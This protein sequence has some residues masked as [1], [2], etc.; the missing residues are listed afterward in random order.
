M[1]PAEQLAFN[2]KASDSTPWLLD[3]LSFWEAMDNT[4]TESLLAL[5]QEIGTNQ[6]RDLTVSLHPYTEQVWKAYE[7]LYGVDSFGGAFDW[8]FLPQLISLI[9]WSRNDFLEGQV[10]IQDLPS[11][12]EMAAKIRELQ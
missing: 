11:P 3:L 8:E 1:T 5:R 4:S 10:V 2:K 9:D 12:A 6:L 7:E